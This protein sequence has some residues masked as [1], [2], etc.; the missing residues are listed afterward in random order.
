MDVEELTRRRPVLCLGFC[1]IL[2]LL[3]YLAALLG[4][5]ARLATLF[6]ML[7]WAVVVLAYVFTPAGLY[8]SRI[9]PT[10]RSRL[11]DELTVA[12]RHTAS[13]A[14]L[15]VTLALTAGGRDRWC[16]WRRD[17]R[18]PRGRHP[19]ADPGRPVHW[20]GLGCPR[21][22][23]RVRCLKDAWSSGSGMPVPARASARRNSRSASVSAARRSTR[24]RTACSCRPPFS[25]CY[26]PGNSACV[27]RTSSV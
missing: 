14:G 18:R 13:M 12:H 5:S 10:D 22:P 1:A 6:G 23:G 7:C 15:A 20:S 2:L 21:A 3:C 4:G 8:G 24:S 16:P 11:C 27:W 26:L 19:G 9:T 17:G 25:P